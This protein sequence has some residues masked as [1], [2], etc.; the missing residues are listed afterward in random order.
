MVLTMNASFDKYHFSTA[1]TRIVIFKTDECQMMTPTF[2]MPERTPTLL[3][4]RLSHEVTL[5]FLLKWHGPFSLLIWIKK[6]LS[7]NSPWGF[8]HVLDT[9]NYYWLCPDERF[10][11]R[12]LPTRWRCNHFSKKWPK[13]KS[14]TTF[15]NKKTF[16]TPTFCKRNFS[17]MHRFGF[18]NFLSSMAPSS[19]V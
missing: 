7:T 9:M 6:N 12:S 5:P 10:F 2:G 1:F 16:V 14:D 17:R 15:T 3:W 11:P 8:E 19:V 13:S 4:C 18:M